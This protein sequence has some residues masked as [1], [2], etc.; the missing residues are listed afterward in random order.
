VNSGLSYRRDIDGLRAVAV[1]LVIAFHAG[2]GTFRNGFLGVDI[3]FVISGYLISGIIFGALERDTFS[4][5]EFYVRR[6]NRILPAL[7]AVL[8]ATACMGWL[9]MY[10]H[11]MSA[12]G[13]HVM[14]GAMFVSNFVLWNGTGYFDLPLKPLL[15]LWSLGVEEQFYLLWPVTA[16]IA[17]KWSRRSVTWVIAG[18]IAVSF[19]IGMLQIATGHAS[20]AFFLPFGRFWE[21]LAGGLLQHLTVNRTGALATT[22]GR[23]TAELGSIAGLALIL[24]AMTM[25]IRD[26]TWPGWP[27]LFPVTGTILLILSGNSTLN[28]RVLGIE[29]LVAIGLISYPLYLW[30]WPVIVFCK[31]I[32]EGYIPPAIASL[33]V[34][35]SFLLSV[36]TFRFIEIPIRFG[37]HKRRSAVRLLYGL[38]LVGVLGIL[39]FIGVTGTHFGGGPLQRRKFGPDWAGPGNATVN[40]GKG[41][42]MVTQPGDLTRTVF[43]IGDSHIAQYWP[44]VEAL[45]GQARGNFPTV[46]ILGYGGCVPLPLIDRRGTDWASKPWECNGI[47]Q[48]ALEH[49]RTPAVKTIVISAWW[50]LYTAGSMEYLV[51]D[52]STVPLGQGDPRL[53]KVF[54]QFERDLASLVAAGKKVYIILPSPTPATQSPKSKWPTRLA[55]FASGKM[56]ANL[57]RDRFDR[58]TGWVSAELRKVAAGSGAHVIDPAEFLC[59]GQLCPMTAPDST[60]VYR[61]DNHLRAAFVAKHATFLDEVF[62]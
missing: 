37:S 51:S 50:E 47:Y 14:A 24:L 28:R 16:V 31:L 48:A 52:T 32:L 12:L 15:H 43:M 41:I 61:D 29:P 59:T 57:S 10:D 58:Q 60:P 34:A 1:L 46:S 22:N 33:A 5:R 13:K 42:L 8:V 6:V 11:E 9:V 49:T 54:D 45:A 26:D 44:R 35:T 36:L 4:F 39:M 30:H 62:R 27:A 18:I 19:T 21:I 56:P 40:H 38:A 7:I 23:W 17:W 20:A 53:E 2:I 3:F 55:R 25:N